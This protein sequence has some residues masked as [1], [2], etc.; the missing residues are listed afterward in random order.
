MSIFGKDKKYTTNPGIE[1][2]GKTEAAVPFEGSFNSEIDSVPPTVGIDGNLPDI[3]FSTSGDSPAIDSVPESSHVKIDQFDHTVPANAINTGSS[4]I[5]LNGT[6]VERPGSSGGFIQPVVGWLVCTKG[7][8]LGQDFRIHSDYN[9]VGSAE[10][11]IIIP[12][13]NKISRRNHMRISFEP[14]SRSFYVSP[15]EGSNYIYLNDEPLESPAKLKDFDVISTGDTELT[16][17]GFCGESFSW[18]MN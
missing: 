14:R 10:G 17:I 3:P 1:Q 18:N 11:D 12:G 8:A 9:R 7:P 5:D 6:I 13:D 2:I 4:F 16:F 15:F